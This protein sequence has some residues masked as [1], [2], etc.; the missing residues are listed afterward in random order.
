MIDQIVSLLRRY[1]I[2]DVHSSRAKGLDIL[3][4]WQWA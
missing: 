2:D 1:I 4:E 3:A